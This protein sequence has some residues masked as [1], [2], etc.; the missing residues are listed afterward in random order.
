M[1]IDLGIILLSEV[2][3]NIENDIIPVNTDEGA[4]FHNLIGQIIGDKLTNRSRGDQWLVSSHSNVDC[5]Y[6]LFE[7]QN[8]NDK[9][10]IS[11]PDDYYQRVIEQN[12][13]LT[14]ANNLVKHWDDFEEGKTVLTDDGERITYVELNKA[15]KL[16][17]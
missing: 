15:Q 9:V 10:I 2:L 8:R 14:I 7:K 5:F 16:A 17:Y 4:N 1:N 6:V 13:Q 3:C 12:M 11:I